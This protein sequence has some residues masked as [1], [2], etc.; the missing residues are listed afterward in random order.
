M[1]CVC[2]TSTDKSRD[3]MMNDDTH[4]RARP[5]HELLHHQLLLV[6]LSLL[7]VDLY[8]CTR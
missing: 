6:D 1:V 3:V 4:V 8:G 2:S 5:C 7:L